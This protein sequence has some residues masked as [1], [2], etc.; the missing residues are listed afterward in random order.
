M[1][2]C[3]LVFQKNRIIK[4]KMATIL[5]FSN[6]KACVYDSGQTAEYILTNYLYDSGLGLNM[7][8]FVSQKNR[9]VKSKMAAILDFFFNWK[10][11]VHDPGQTAEYSLTKF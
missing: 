11:C 8:W 9:I 5:N 3:W 7:C 4:S 1:D 10:A 6:W 2:M